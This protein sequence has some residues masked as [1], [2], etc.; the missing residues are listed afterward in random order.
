MSIALMSVSVLAGLV[1]AG[2]PEFVLRAFVISM[3]PLCD[4]R[5]QYQCRASAAGGFLATRPILRTVY[6]YI[7]P[8]PLEFSSNVVLEKELATLNPTAL[9]LSGSP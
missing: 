1:D 8:S 5:A 7:M 6:S 3:A 4:Y 9:V 2:L